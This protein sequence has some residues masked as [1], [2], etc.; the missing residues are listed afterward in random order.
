VDVIELSQ[1]LS[2]QKFA[3]WTEEKFTQF[4][5]LSGCD[6]LGSLPGVGISTAYK[7]MQAQKS[8]HATLTH[9]HR[10]NSACNAQYVENFQRALLTFRHQRV[11]DP[12]RKKMLPLTPLNTACILCPVLEDRSMA[13]D[14]VA[15]LQPVL[16]SVPSSHVPQCVAAALRSN[17]DRN[18]LEWG[19]YRIAGWSHLSSAV[20]HWLH[21]VVLAVAGTQTHA[22]VMVCT[23]LARTLG[24]CIARQLL[25]TPPPLQP[26]RASQ[27]ISLL[28]L[29]LLGTARQGP[30]AFHARVHDFSK[31]LRVLRNTE[32]MEG[33]AREMGTLLLLLVFAHPGG[34]GIYIYM[35]MF[36]SI[37]RLFFF[38]FFFV[39]VVVVIMRMFFFF[40]SFFLKIPRCFSFIV[41]FFLLH[42]QY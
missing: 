14:E 19:V 23:R 5:I 24:E 32:R 26:E 1:I 10:V 28:S 40:S 39:V 22:D 8:I 41:Y 3:N 37:S 30:F 6:Y 25:T 36:I 16:E 15:R 20:I 27:L 7:T 33:P 35:F 17:P 42:M 12:V 31:I 13:P 11:Y 34:G 9:F 21:S 38:F 18:I 2:S 29:L 4:C